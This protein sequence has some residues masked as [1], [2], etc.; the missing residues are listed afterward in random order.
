M[1]ILCASHK[2]RIYT[3]C[4]IRIFV[5]RRFWTVHSHAN[6]CFLTCKISNDCNLKSIL[7]VSC[8]CP[9]AEYRRDGTSIVAVASAITTFSFSFHRYK[10]YTTK[11]VAFAIKRQ[12]LPLQR[13][14]HNDICRKNGFLH[15]DNFCH[16]DSFRYYDSFRHPSI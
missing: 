9:T 2:A 1:K 7:A 11:K 4:C 12:L 3:V 6:M 16:N 8:K 15:R 14:R 13:F 10:S 5:L